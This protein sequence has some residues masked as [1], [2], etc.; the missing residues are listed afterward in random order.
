MIL[1]SKATTGNGTVQEIT[2]LGNCHTVYITWLSGTTSGGITLETAPYP[3]YT[4]TWAAI[5]PEI[6]VASGAGTCV[7]VN[8]QHMPLACIRARV[9]TT[10][11]GG[12]TPGVTV[13]VETS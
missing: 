8:I 6:L 11:A 10:V 13:D 1:Q 12:A 5:L 3:G 2:D 9:S 7:T 4:G